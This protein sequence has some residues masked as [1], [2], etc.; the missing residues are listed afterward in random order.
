MNQQPTNNQPTT[1]HN[2]R[3]DQQM[4]THFTKQ[5][6]DL[7]GFFLTRK[8]TTL[9][10]ILSL[11]IAATIPAAAQ[12]GIG[13]STPH[14]SAVLELQATNKGVLFPRVALTGKSD[15]TTIPSPATSLVV[16]NTAT[17]GG[18]VPGFYYWN[19]TAWQSMA[20]D[21][22]ISYIEATARTPQ[23]TQY[24]P[25]G[26]TW[27]PTLTT[28]GG[29]G[30]AADG[31]FTAAS[32]GYYQINLHAEYRDDIGDVITMQTGLAFS[33]NAG[34]VT[35]G[36]VLNAFPTRGGANFWNSLNATGMV[37]MSAGET[38]GP[39]LFFRGG[40]ISFDTTERVRNVQLVVVRMSAD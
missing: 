8:L 3:K 5:L 20:G 23:G 26:V 1:G 24:T 6:S 9:L 33:A 21:E 4:N 27:T 29:G 11:L 35:N 16:Y 34:D 22:F 32:A 37:Y 2:Q 12:V 28:F 25:T 19:G 13:T 30:I 39:I 36:V 15:T 31:T 18:L 17:A 40:G 7:W 14:T 38:L 10:L